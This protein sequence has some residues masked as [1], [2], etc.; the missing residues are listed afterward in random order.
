MKSMVIVYSG[1]EGS[2]AIVSCLGKHSRINVPIFEDLDYANV[3]KRFGKAGVDNIHVALAN[4]LKGIEFNDGVIEPVARK[5]AE[6]RVVFKWR[7]FGSIEKIC[8]VFVDSGTVVAALARKDFL[9]YCIS[10]YYTDVILSEQS[11][12]YHPQFEL[13]KMSPSQR[14]SRIEELRSRSFSVDVE[15]FVEIMQSVIERK[16]KIQSVTR[17]MDRNGVV[18]KHVFYED[19]LQNKRGFLT[20]LLAEMDLEFEEVVTES[21]FV[22][23][24]RSDMRDQVL[25]I[26]ELEADEE[27][28]SLK[29]EYSALISDLA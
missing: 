14:K 21:N 4:V 24:N 10:R 2:S 1:R 28:Q 8:D 6:S 7:P 3:K 20:A 15:S 13:M 18:V 29:I 12:I 19:F 26:D 17:Q 5:S 16:V 11:A 25:N 9:N 27:I 23:V 22:K